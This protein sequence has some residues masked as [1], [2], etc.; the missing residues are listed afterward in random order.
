M[1]RIGQSAALGI[2]TGLAGLVI[3]GIFVAFHLDESW[4]LYL[5]F[6]MRGVRQAP[7]QVVV[8][9]IDRTS[10]ARLAVDEEPGK[11]PRSYHGDLTD[12]LARK[13]ASVIVFDL[14]FHDSRSYDDDAAFARAVGSAGNVVLTEYL[15]QEVLVDDRGRKIENVHTEKRIGPIPVLADTAASV[16]GFP[17]PKYPHRVNRYWT[18]RPAGGGVPT[19]PVA[20]FQ[21]YA[22][23]VYDNLV[24]L[25]RENSP[26]RA[27]EDLPAGT[28]AF[29]NSSA[30]RST[31]KALRE[32]FEQDPALGDRLTETLTAA[33]APP[34][35]TGD[36]D[37]LKSLIS[38]YRSPASAYLNYYGP[39]RTIRTIPYN[40][41]LLPDESSGSA[42]PSDFR[43]K[44]VFVGLSEIMESEKR[45][46]S[47]STVFSLPNG[48]DISGVEIAATAF[49]NILEGRPLLRLGAAWQAVII[50]CWGFFAGILFDR[51]VPSVLS[52]REAALPLAFVIASGTVYVVIAQYAFAAGSLW[53]PLTVPVL[54]TPLALF[55]AVALKTIERER[56][57]YGI[58]LFT[59]IRGF[60]KLSEN[61][62]PASLKHVMGNYFRLLSGIIERRGGVT[63]NVPGD[64]I[65]ARWELRGPSRS[66]G[67]ERQRACLAALEIARAV[68][69]PAERTG[70]RL[71][72]RVGVHCGP[73]SRGYIGS[74]QQRKNI[75]F[76]DTVNTSQRAEEMNKCLGTQVLVSDD[77][78]NGLEG[79]L[80]RN[81]GRFVLSGKSKTLELHEL[82]CPLEEASP[83]E[84]R[85]C[86][87]FEKAL[88]A[89]QRRS[90]DEASLQFNRIIRE[91]GH[92]G[93]S[94]YYVSLCGS[95]KSRPPDES[96]RGAVCQDEKSLAVRI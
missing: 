40:R 41:I 59:D 3:G 58:Y 46:D 11:W 84:K 34:E 24:R 73:A 50:F 39:P 26:H 47:F 22:S 95:Y 53:L 15:R 54:Q 13:G 37:L 61:M 74:R 48:V 16:A 79:F 78:I 33:H 43:G 93:P 29:M 20:A 38:M 5:L 65:L 76:G 72:S 77:M 14:F 56:T 63:E 52:P 4:D 82:L 7:P 19:L 42:M 83:E 35:R 57:G 91:F 70:I 51:L 80:T 86:T 23:S 67:K 27:L 6:R 64:A 69:E 49:A 25:I 18:F 94:L 36:S 1:T 2:V 8:V 30:T 89:F 32:I 9:S 88:G 90:W 45:N 75:T 60:T 12:R 66:S 62:D 87:L 28:E 68:S 55:G 44:A 71:S 85:L 10:A 31:M 81:V 21:V 96:W 92:D 17:L